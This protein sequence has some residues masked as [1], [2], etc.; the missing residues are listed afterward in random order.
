MNMRRAALGGC[1]ALTLGACA[2]Q[3]CAPDSPPA[4][5][6][7]P[8]SS[9]EADTGVRWVVDV[10][11]ATGSVDLAVPLGPTAPEMR[12]GESPEVAARRFIARYKQLFKL[13]D[14]Q[15][16]L[17]LEEVAT[18]KN[19]VTHVRFIQRE[20]GVR[21]FG[22]YLTVHFKKDGSIALVTGPIVPDAVKGAGAPTIDAARAIAAAEAD[23]RA[24]VPSYTPASQIAPPQPELVLLPSGATA[25]LVFRLRIGGHAAVPYGFVYA[26]DAKTGAIASVHGDLETL[27]G[28][29]V[30][31]L[32]DTK[33]FEIREM[34]SPA[35][36]YALYQGG[37]GG[38]GGRE[39]I[40]THTFGGG[41]GAADPVIH[42][43][44]MNAWDP[45][46][47][48]GQGSA[49]D[50]HKYTSDVDQWFRKRV[51]WASYDGR[52]SPMKVIVHE[53]T[54]ANQ[55]NAYWDNAGGMHYNDGDSHNPGG[56]VRPTSAALDVTGHELMHGVTQHTSGLQYAGESGALNEALSDIFGTFIEREYVPIGSS[57]WTIGEAAWS[58]GGIRDFIHPSRFN[59]PD[60]MSNLMF[61][62][63]APAQ[64][65]DWGGV[66]FNSGIINNAWFL[67]TW[68]GTNDTSKIAVT[69]SLGFDDSRRLWW[70]TSRFLLKPTSTFDQ[71]AR[72]QLGW[73]KS[74]NLPIE[75]VG[76][77]WVATGVLK[78][79]YVEGNYGV[80]CGCG[81]A[82]AGLEDGGACAPEAGAPDAAAPDAAVP[83]GGGGI[84]DGEETEVE[85][86]DSC[87]GR[88][89]GVYCS[90]LSASGS[91]V[92]KDQTI[93][94]GLQC[95]N[96]AK[97]IGPNGPG[98]T[99]Q[100]EG[101]AAPAP[102]GDAGAPPRPSDSCAGRPDGVYCSEASPYSA[103]VC[104][105]ES[106][107]GGLACNPTQLCIGPNGPGTTIQCQ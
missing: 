26:V 96:A 30:G 21:V 101:Q 48:S 56:N 14:P 62:G 100:C 52:G 17:A 6:A 98:T 75:A 92:C 60:H 50:A 78:R 32:G 42:S 43:D 107:A 18:P 7:T 71:A 94:A 81:D 1:L 97:C 58:G 15:N 28:S 104:K 80:K 57:L 23:V 73:A 22:A 29:G 77:A 37:V 4:P 76:C 31:S 45:Q 79:E 90:E 70:A 55:N 12:R 27:T 102:G 66:H 39:R 47:V 67:M 85:A 87:K 19:G 13:T 33:T 103:L 35:G 64:N 9:L 59:Q 91:I 46:P 38:Q 93:S 2:L 65:N 72:G 10:D 84:P 25:K 16:Q 106:I 83:D 89:D 68:G 105:G 54:A 44:D 8:G 99:V 63:Q 61:G 5:R 40:V 24:R 11:P 3:A 88:A 95:A 51:G 41:N 34:P 49:V 36:K 86:F 53:N 82:D 74:N 20:A 69:R